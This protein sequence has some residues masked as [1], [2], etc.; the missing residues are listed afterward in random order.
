MH[1]KALTVVV[2]SR[3]FYFCCFIFIY[4][5]IYLFLMV[6]VLEFGGA[7]PCVGAL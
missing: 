6:V 1:T 2:K 5:F 7:G 4:L 3:W